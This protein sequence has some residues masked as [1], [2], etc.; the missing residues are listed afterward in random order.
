MNDYHC[1]NCGR[2]LSMDKDEIWRCMKCE[3]N[4]V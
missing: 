4:E 2:W 3:K 1:K